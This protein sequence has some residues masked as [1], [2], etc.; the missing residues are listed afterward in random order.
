[1][2]AQP[3]TRREGYARGLRRPYSLG[4]EA[5]GNPTIQNPYAREREVGVAA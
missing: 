5:S 3:F 4:R 2:T 1:M